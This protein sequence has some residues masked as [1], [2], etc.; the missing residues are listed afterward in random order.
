MTRSL[1]IG[2]TVRYSGATETGKGN[3]PDLL[4][5]EYILDIRVNLY[6]DQIVRVP[7]PLPLRRKYTGPVRAETVRFHPDFLCDGLR[8][9]I[10]APLADPKTTRQF[11]E[12]IESTRLARAS[13]DD[14]VKPLQAAAAKWNHRYFWR[15]TC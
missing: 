8:G 15:P 11:V 4:I 1:R 12:S 3:D 10:V 2:E 5:Q 13:H 7:V 14:H 6:R 9:R